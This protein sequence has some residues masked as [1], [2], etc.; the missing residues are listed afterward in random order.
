[1]D[2]LTKN[3]TGRGDEAVV[4]MV[5]AS[6]VHRPGADISAGRVDRAQVTQDSL[7]STRRW[8]HY[9]ASAGTIRRLDI[10]VLLPRHVERLRYSLPAAVDPDPHVHHVL[11][12][13]IPIAHPYGKW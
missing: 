7:Q 6:T 4:A 11:V 10:P 1:M 13:H 8:Q 3:A 5:P 12:L 2:F 9:F